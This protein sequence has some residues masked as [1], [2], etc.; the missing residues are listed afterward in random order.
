M[1]D[2]VQTESG[3]KVRSYRDPAV[4]AYHSS[5]SRR[6]IPAL[7]FLGCLAYLCVFLRYSTLEPD[8][9]IVLQGA[10][11]VLAGQIPYRDFFSFY[12]P[13][14]LYLLAATFRIFGD[15]FAV[16][17]LSLAVVGAI[18][19]VLTYLLARRVCTVGTSIF[20]AV[21]ATTAGTAF[22]FLVLHNPYSTLGSCLCLYAAVR[23]LEH[24]QVRWAFLVGSFASLTFLTEQSKG[25]GLYLGL[26]L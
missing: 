12:T 11:R 17:R 24:R 19:S 10:E 1:T 8:E 6:M 21:L 15:S 13:G 5:L 25:A 22:R 14:S 4:P 23:L 26:V 9:G 2:T 20:V 18:C 16:A 3:L 7:I